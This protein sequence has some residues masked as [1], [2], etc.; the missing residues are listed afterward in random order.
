[1]RWG[2]AT[3][4]VLGVIIGGLVVLCYAPILRALMSQWINDAD[5][6]H[7]FFVPLVPAISCGNAGKSC[8][9]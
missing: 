8:W 6:G 4:L 7:G 1:M 9:P 3:I 2:V 5:M